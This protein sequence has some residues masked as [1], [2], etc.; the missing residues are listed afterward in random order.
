[1][2]PGMRFA[3]SGLRLLFTLRETSDYLRPLA[4]AAQYTSERTIIV[5]G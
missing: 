2:F 5:F 4:L 1:M 3:P